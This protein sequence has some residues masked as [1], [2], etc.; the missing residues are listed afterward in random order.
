MTKIKKAL[1]SFIIIWLIIFCSGAAD[2]AEVENLLSNGGFEDGVVEPWIVYGAATLNVVNTDAVEGTN[3]LQVTVNEKGVNYW[4]T[5]LVYEGLIFE[6]GKVYT[7][8]AFLKSQ[9]KLNIN[10][11]LSLGE[12]PWTGYGQMNFTMTDEWR[13]YHL[14][15]PPM[16][17]NVQPAQ[18]TFHIAFDV[19]TF[20]I[21][22]VQF[23]EGEYIPDNPNAFPV[24]SAQPPQNGM[25]YATWWSGRYSNPLADSSLANLAATGAT[26]ISLIVTAYQETNASTDISHTTAATPT[27]DELIHVIAEAHHLGLKVML[28][29]HVDLLTDDPLQWRGLIGDNFTAESEWAAWFASYRNV[30]FH[31]A[32]L[33]ETHGAD[34][35]CVGTELL[36]TSH[37]EDD[38]REVIAGVRTRYSGPITYA[39]NHSGEELNIIWWDAID[40]IGVDAYY[41]LTNLN[42]PTLDELKAGWEQGLLTLSNLAYI[43]EKPILLTEIG[44]RSLDGTNRTPSNWWNQGT[45]DLQEQA[46]AYTAA[47]ES[48]YNRPWFAG[49]FWWSWE[50]DPFEGGDCNQDYTP[51]DKPAE[52]V[53]RTWYGVPPRPPPP[54]PSSPPDYNNTIDIYIDELGSGW[55]DWSWDATRN[56]AATD[57]V[58]GGTH[59]ISFTLE[60]RGGLTFWHS[61][62]DASPYEWLEFYIHGGSSEEEGDLWVFCY[63]GDGTELNKRPVN[64]CR[65]IEGGNIEPIWKRVRI[66]LLHLDARGKSLTRVAIQNRSDDA[67][68]PLWIDEIRL[69]APSVAAKY[70]DVNNDG[71]VGVGDAMLVLKF[72]VRLIDLNLLQREMSDVSGDGNITAYDAVFILQHIVGLISKFPAEETTADAPSLSAKSESDA[73]REQIARLEA[74]NLT[75]AQRRVLE[76]LKSLANLH[77]DLSGRFPSLQL[78]PKKTRLL[79]NYPNPFNPET[80]LPYQL[81]SD[82]E[83]TLRIYDMG[84]RVIQQLD[85]GTRPAGLY[86]SRERAAYWDG[87]SGTGELMSSGLYFY[88]LRAGNLTA[89]KRMIILK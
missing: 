43:W 9:D 39:S 52:D 45:I 80:W 62:F 69:I 86:F 75:D 32:E 65:Y 56:L 11:N 5:G 10:F 31:Y 81:A 53:L 87:R 16:P 68:T 89:V 85:L 1:F 6:E 74:V 82:A 55:E 83:I 72:V 46:D 36:G 24:S 61:P 79:Q 60:A 7:L 78:V 13:E 84:G 58:Y 64:D 54:T 66:P 48:V 17:E 67:S 2:S 26:W 22:G 14:T 18:I 23:Y 4:D 76:Q 21:D 77:P 34:Q 12:D 44:Y 41:P 47:F 73:L 40:Y 57:P 20:M 3:S 42:D 38:W 29:P 50:I 19:G 35:F 49:M 51:H 88:E 30:I 28:K 33:A 59:T 27:D 15:T 37:R 71:D 8:S 63:D 70:G 25:S